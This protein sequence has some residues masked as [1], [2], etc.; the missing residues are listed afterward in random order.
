MPFA[1]IAKAL[2]GLTRRKLTAASREEM[3]SEQSGLRATEDSLMRPVRAA[4]E[5]ICAAQDG[6]SSADGGVARHYSLQDGWGPSYPE[7]TGY[8]IPT[9]LE[10]SHELG[11]RLLRLRARR[12]AHW[13]VRIQLPDGSFQGGT[14]FDTPKVP[15]VFNTGQILFGLAAAARDEGESFREPLARAAEWLVRVQDRDG[16]WRKYPSPFAGPGERAYDTHV[17]WGML[18]AARVL[19]D[20]AVYDAALRNIRASLRYQHLNGFVGSCCLSDPTRPLTHT[21]GYFLRGVL[22][23]YFASHEPALLDGAMRLGLRL[24]DAVSADGFLAGRIDRSFR[25]SV[26]WSCLTGSAQIAHC[27]LQLFE[28]TGDD[29]FF[30]VGS[31]LNRFVASTV[32]LDGESAARWSEGLVP[33]QR[34]LQ[35]VSVPQLGRQILY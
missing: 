22:E 27:L 32:H 11:D 19:R 29:S 5:W 25:A 9:L 18:E 4:V 20:S 14:V 24:R 26:S 35:R 30:V 23:G 28:L 21:I 6:S 31:R 8:I 15:V 17:A 34:R 33:R 2:D 3:R 1:L 13:L 16:V 12:M 10:C 7:T